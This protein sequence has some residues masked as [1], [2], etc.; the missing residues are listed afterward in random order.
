MFLT[1]D[2]EYVE[3]KSS[4]NDKNFIMENDHELEVESD[5]YQRG[6]L[7]ALSSQQR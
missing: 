5:D 3:K 7:N 6:Y 2:E 1:E 4:P